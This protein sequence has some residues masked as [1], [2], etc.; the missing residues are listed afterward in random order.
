MDNGTHCRPQYIY[1]RMFINYL[2]KL[3][4]YNTFFECNSI[5][6]SSTKHG[7]IEIFVSYKYLMLNHF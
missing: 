7:V 6:H 5:R 3:Y 4:K 2:M 1:S